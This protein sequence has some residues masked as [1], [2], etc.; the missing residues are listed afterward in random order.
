MHYDTTFP[1]YKNFTDDVS[2][3]IVINPNPTPP[4]DH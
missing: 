2:Q 1:G 4:D 3:K